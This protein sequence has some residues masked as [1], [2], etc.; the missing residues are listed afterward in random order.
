MKSRTEAHKEFA[1][2]YRRPRS[3][4][5]QQKVDEIISKTNDIFMRIELINKLDAE[6][7]KG[8]PRKLDDYDSSSERSHEKRSFSEEDF[9]NLEKEQKKRTKSKKKKKP[10]KK[11]LFL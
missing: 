10:L 1:N 8:D 6:L 2:L 9:K 5:D 3:P 11:D 7:K 4:E